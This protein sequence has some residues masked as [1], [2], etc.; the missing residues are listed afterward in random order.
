MTGRAPGQPD[1]VANHYETLLPLAHKLDEALQQ[2]YDRM[3]SQVIETVGLNER[4]GKI[5]DRSNVEV[6]PFFTEAGASP[7]DLYFAFADALANRIMPELSAHSSRRES[8]RIHDLVDWNDAPT[9]GN[10]SDRDFLLARIAHAR[11]K[12]MADFLRQ[13]IIRYKPESLPRA[14]SLRA[15]EDLISTFSVVTAM[16]VAIPVRRPAAIRCVM[17]RGPEDPMWQVLPRHH[18]AI[19]KGANALATLSLL[20]GQYAIAS[21]IGD[22]LTALDVRLGQTMMRYEPG[23]TFQASAFLKLSL[24]RDGADFHFGQSLYDL[25]A[26]HLVESVPD[27]QLVLH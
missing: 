25:M 11:S 21:A 1:A 3:E 2:A 4:V 23:Q 15:I 7:R 24:Q 10:L 19:I 26:Q 6:L 27:I 16:G 12:T 14:A 20:K 17:T 9:R 22:M 18:T 8:Y 13:V 5:L